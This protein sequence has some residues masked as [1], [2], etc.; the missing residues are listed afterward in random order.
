MSDINRFV[1]LEYEK[2]FNEL[3]K[4]NRFYAVR[5]FLESGIIPKIESILYACCN[6][7]LDIVKLL[8][9]KCDFDVN[10]VFREYILCMNSRGKSLSMNS[11]ES[12]IFD[13]EV[14]FYLIEEGATFNESVRDELSFLFCYFLEED[15]LERIFT[16]T[17]ILDV[18]DL[19]EYIKTMDMNDVP[20]TFIKNIF[21]ENPE[22]NI[23]TLVYLLSYP[24]SVSYFEFFIDRVHEEQ[25]E[26]ITN[27]YFEYDIEH[28]INRVKILVEK[29]YRITSDDLIK[30]TSFSSIT[31][32]EKILTSIDI[33]SNVLDTIKSLSKQGLLKDQI[34]SLR[35]KVLYN[36]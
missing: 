22:L 24:C 16:E 29:G 8:L 33:D 20:I 9:S 23:D 19:N 35:N 2:E 34:I 15:I 18:F 12:F 5:M 17:N 4:D 3:C 25:L 28:N 30:I 13:K 32:F 7:N 10:E 26:K 6:G 31:G 36:R 21:S 14:F 27:S 11:L 1:E